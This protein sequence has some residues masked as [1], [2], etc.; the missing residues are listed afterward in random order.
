MSTPL[1]LGF[2]PCPN[3]TFIFHALVHGLVPQ[4]P[5]FDPILLEDV[6]TLN[7]WALQ[8]K[9]DVSKLS[10]HALGQVLDEYVLL[11]DGAAL[12]R[13]C[14]PLLVA[15]EHLDPAELPAKRLAI[16][17]R[18]TTAAMLLGL[19]APAV[20]QGIAA[21]AGQLPPNLRQMRFDRIMPALVAGEIDAGVI[22]HESRFTYRAHGLKLLVDLGAWWEQVSGLP[23]PLGGIA[24]RRSL[25]KEKLAAVA[26]AIKQ[27]L[28]RAR[29]QPAAA[30]EYIRRHAGELDSEVMRAHI[31]LY[32]N[33]FSSDLGQEGERAVAEFIRRGRAAGILPATNQ[34]LLLDKRV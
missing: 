6:E 4:A 24:A 15:R 29:R 3:D 7:Q 10:F 18:Y 12:G 33:D 5:E 9:L 22:I 34:R 30:M 11:P 28:A 26:E 8:G 32:V 19:Y 16:P 27:S 21:G 17:G 23:I 20:W 14:G 31:D 2:S 1:S 13:G 25:G